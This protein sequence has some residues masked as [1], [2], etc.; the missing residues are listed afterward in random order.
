[1]RLIL[2]D[3]HVFFGSMNF[4]IN[5]IFVVPFVLRE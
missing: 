1:M 3:A 5:I 2:F 4:Y